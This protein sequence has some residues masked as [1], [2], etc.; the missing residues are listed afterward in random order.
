MILQIIYFYF[1]EHSI[2]LT[3]FIMRE[4]LQQLQIV[5]RGDL[6]VS[7]K[8][9]PNLFKRVCRKSEQLLIEFL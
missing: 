5:L 9:H 2:S 3:L 1:Y 6:Y 8:A 4:P 7:L